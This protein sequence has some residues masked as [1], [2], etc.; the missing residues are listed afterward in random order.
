[1][2]PFVAPLSTWTAL[3]VVLVASLTNC[4]EPSSGA[5][6]SACASPCSSGLT[7]IQRA[8][9]QACVEQP[10]LGRAPTLGADPDGGA[11]CRYDPASPVATDSL[12]SGFR[13][14]EI[15]ANFVP[16][17]PDELQLTL[18]EGTRVTACSI[19]SCLPVVEG[20]A[21]V[22]FDACALTFE[23]LAPAQ[24]T[25]SLADPS[26]ER[27]CSTAA[28]PATASCATVFDTLWVACWSYDAT[29]L[30]AATRLNPVDPRGTYLFSRSLK[31]CSAAT[32]GQ[33]CVLAATNRVGACVGGACMPHCQT[34]Q[35]CDTALIDAPPPD[36]A[37]TPDD[38]GVDPDA[39]AELDASSGP[40]LPKC[41]FYCDALKG[42]EDIGVCKPLPH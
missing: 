28:G 19:F 32:E 7:C 5:P 12:T 4:D 21:I 3:V 41:S 40:H 18:V 22:N 37:S 6:P 14:G 38:A 36:T 35:D 15:P 34:P 42:R 23:I 9:T 8:A 16:E 1:M 20:D 27:R 29:H 30:V 25:V 39:D 13:V 2:R 10:S 31:A 33:S 26:R 24:S 17:H 11:A